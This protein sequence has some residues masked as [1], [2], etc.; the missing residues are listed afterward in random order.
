MVSL[1]PERT[2]TQ[3]RVATAAE[4]RT[5]IRLTPLQL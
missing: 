2:Y 4:Q 1:I 5:V 3:T